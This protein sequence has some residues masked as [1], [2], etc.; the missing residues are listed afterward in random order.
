MAWL[1]RARARTRT[2]SDLGIDESRHLLLTP[3]SPLLAAV[4]NAAAAPTADDVIADGC[5]TEA[6]LL[7]AAEDRGIVLTDQEVQAF[8]ASEGACVP[9]DAQAF[10]Q[11]YLDSLDLSEEGR[12]RKDSGNVF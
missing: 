6:E 1:R 3:P 10:L 5:I 11:G 2:P 8:L 4:A 7:D 12:K 9:Q